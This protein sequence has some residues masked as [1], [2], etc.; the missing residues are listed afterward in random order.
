MSNN[1]S[2]VSQFKIKLERIEQ[3]SSLLEDPD[4]DLEQAILLYEEGMKLSQECLS[5]LK[6]AELKITELK[7]SFKS[8]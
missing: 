3:I 2:E 5:S 8:Y 1:T 4:L 7:N 6:Q